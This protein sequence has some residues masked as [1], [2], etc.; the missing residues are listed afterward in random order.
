MVKADA[1]LPRRIEQGCFLDNE[2]KPLWLPRTDVFVL[3]QDA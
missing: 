1:N 2:K 3:R